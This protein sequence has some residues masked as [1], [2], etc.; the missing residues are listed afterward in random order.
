MSHDSNEKR[1]KTQDR[2]NWTTKS[3]QNQNARRKGNLQILA[4]I[5]SWKHQTSVDERKFFLK[6]SQ[7]KQN[8][9]RNKTMLQEPYKKD[10]YRGYS[11]RK[12]LGT[13]LE[14]YQRR[15]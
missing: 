9:S 12:T 13:I 8:T 15:T 7:K 2:R 14:V 10:K 4:N 6:V 11:P 5:G 1:E 3:K